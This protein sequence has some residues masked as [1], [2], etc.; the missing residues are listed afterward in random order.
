[1]DALF[2]PYSDSAASQ[3]LATENGLVLA[4]RISKCTPT[5]R[6]VE[7]RLCQIHA[8][9]F[10]PTGSLHCGGASILQYC[11]LVYFRLYCAS[12]LRQG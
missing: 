8:N 5:M 7:A 3:V 11:S 6:P 12:E 10:P 9:L 2:Y 4:G 1:M